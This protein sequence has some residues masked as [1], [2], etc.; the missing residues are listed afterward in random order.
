MHSALLKP[1]LLITIVLILP[2]LVIALSGEMFLP[3]VERW[4]DNPPTPALL[5]TLIAAIL[6]SDVF[7]PVPS[8]PVSTL[9]GSA[10]GAWPGA[11]TS[12]LG[13]TMGAAIAF[14]LARRWGRPLA[15]RWTSAERL[16]DLEA[17]CREHG[18][19]MLV[20]TRPLPILAEACALLT[21]ALQMSWTRFLPAVVAS[22]L[23][24]SAAYAHLGEQATQQGWLPLALCMAVAA[25]LAIAVVWRRRLRKTNL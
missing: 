9:A 22:N 24:I 11:L 7:L 8:G 16:A 6:A 4:R 21:G 1:L 12:C 25:P 5:A 20:V 13:M 23:V 17:A 10:L 19:W 2:L 18:L 15:Q 14:G 3:Q